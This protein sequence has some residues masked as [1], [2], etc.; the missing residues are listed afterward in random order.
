MVV[1][2]VEEKEV[3]IIVLGHQVPIQPGVDVEG[4]R[5]S[6]MLVGLRGQQ[7]QAGEGGGVG[8]APRGQQQRRR[9]QQ[10]R[11]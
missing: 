3:R 7:R 5:S 4:R 6:V 9:Q 10:Q 8:V 2:A 1:P 11:Q